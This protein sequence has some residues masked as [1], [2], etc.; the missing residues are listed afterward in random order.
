MGLIVRV[1]SIDTEVLGDI[2]GEIG[3]LKCDQSRSN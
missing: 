3:L 1:D 2:F